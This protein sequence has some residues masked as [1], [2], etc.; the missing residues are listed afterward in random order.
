MVK[1][2]LEKDQLWIKAN[3][4]TFTLHS[5]GEV[6]VDGF[7]SENYQV[8]GLVDVVMKFLYLALGRR[9]A[10]ATNCGPN[11]TYKLGNLVFN[12]SWDRLDL[13][14][15]DDKFVG[16]I[17]RY[18]NDAWFRTP[19][20]VFVEE[21][22][23]FIEITRKLEH[24]LE[25]YKLLAP[26]EKLRFEVE[27]MKLVC[28]SGEAKVL[29]VEPFGFNLYF[30]CF[31]YNESKMV[32]SEIF[33]EW[34]GNVLKSLIG[35]IREFEYE[36]IDEVSCAVKYGYFTFE[37]NKR[38]ERLSSVWYEAPGLRFKCNNLGCEF[39]GKKARLF[40]TNALHIWDDVSAKLTPIFQ[41]VAAYYLI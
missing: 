35:E 5:S 40:F 25:K 10:T 18:T 20:G 13:K 29:E 11:L 9:K 30:R 12:V 17:Y 2:G 23:D 28:R 21:G 19:I 16:Y 15:N 24:I 32:D 22:Y 34:L 8:S 27:G 36:E 14:T 37:Y 38:R 33:V 41:K 4:K 3:W 39:G 1:F 31:S 7:G 26:F 6:S